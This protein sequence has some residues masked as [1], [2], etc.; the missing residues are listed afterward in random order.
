MRQ[1]IT[2][3]VPPKGTRPSES[4]WQVTWFDESGNQHF[5]GKFYSEDTAINFA[6]S[7]AHYPD[8]HP[9]N[10]DIQVTW[11]RRGGI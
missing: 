9:T 6:R 7:V 2:L 11:G 3:H 8:L 4:Q 1:V 5:S 10:P